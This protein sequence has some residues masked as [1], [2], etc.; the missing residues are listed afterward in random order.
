MW[1]APGSITAQH[2]ALS[3]LSVDLYYRFTPLESGAACFAEPLGF[4]MDLTSLSRYSDKGPVQTRN[5]LCV[6]KPK[7]EYSLGFLPNKNGILLGPSIH[8]LP[9][10]YISYAYCTGPVHRPVKS[11]EEGL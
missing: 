3:T 5:V 8:F 2:T 1:S 4:D 10:T 6:L 11:K 9:G 7:M